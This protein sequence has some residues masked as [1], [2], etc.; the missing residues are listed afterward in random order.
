MRPA[1]ALADE[2]GEAVRLQAGDQRLVDIDALPAAGMELERGLAI[3]GDA[4]AA[5]AVGFLQGLAPEHGGRAAEEGG[6]PLVEAA[7][8][9]AVEHLVLGRHGLE[10]AEIAL[11]RV[12]IDE[13]VRRLDQE[14]ALVLGEVPD[15]LGEEA[16]GRGVVG[17]EDGDQI[18]GRVLEAVV[19]VAGLGM[20]VAGAGQV[21][22][23]EGRAHGLQLGA[24]FARLLGG[25]GVARIALLVRAAVVEKPD[26]HLVGGIGHGL[27]GGERGGQQVGTLVV[28]RDE[29]VDG[30]QVLRVDLGSL[31]RRQRARHH[32]KAQE[33]HHDAVHL[34]QIEQ[35]ARDEA[36]HLGDRRDGAGGAPEDVAQDDGGAESQRDQAPDAL[37]AHEL[38]DDHA[39]HDREARNEMR[40]KADGKSHDRHDQYRRHSPQGHDKTC[41]H[42]LCSRLKGFAWE[43]GCLIEE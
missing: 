36:R 40:L 34:G 27:R 23:V 38:D 20:H 3:L 2:A 30:R 26:R 5:E 42:R 28:A 8:D 10:R 32:E 13:E 6:I 9:D 22:H 19:E 17:I 37:G 4:D 29:D 31:A 18:A 7:L 43:E 39:G 15:R 35:E 14:Q 12:G 33:Q 25:G 11:E 1:R 21:F 41:S 16:A 24:A